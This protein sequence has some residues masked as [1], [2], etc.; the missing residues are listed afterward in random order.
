MITMKSWND[1]GKPFS[2]F[3]KPGDEVDEEIYMYFLEVLPPETMETKGGISM[4]QVGEASDTDPKT[5]KY[6]YATFISY[7]DL[8]DKGNIIEKYQYKGDMVKTK[9]TA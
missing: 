1:S 7:K 4:F 8:D 6:R 5:G 3:A 2:E 9:I